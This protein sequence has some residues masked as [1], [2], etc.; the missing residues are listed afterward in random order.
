MYP[1]QL[2]CF[3]QMI[4]FVNKLRAGMPDTTLARMA[5]C[6]SIADC[7]DHHHNNWLAQLM[8]FCDTIQ[9]PVLNVQGT[10]GVPELDE[11]TC[12]EKLLH[13]CITVFSPVLALISQGPRN[14]T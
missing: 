5:L 2:I 13:E 3:R 4:R 6:D 10:G 9:A 7:R 8:S 12:I 14:T 11:T 1:W